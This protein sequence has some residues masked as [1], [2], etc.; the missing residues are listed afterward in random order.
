VHRI[1]GLGIPGDGSDPDPNGSGEPPTCGG[2][3]GN[4]MLNAEQRLPVDRL[5]RPLGQLSRP[6]PV[7]VPGSRNVQQVLRDLCAGVRRE[8]IMVHDQAASREAGVLLPVATWPGVEVRALNGMVLV[9]YLAPGEP[10]ERPEAGG[11]TRVNG[12]DRRRRPVPPPDHGGLRLLLVDRSAA[13]VPLQPG[14]TFAGGVLL[15]RDPAVT[16]SLHTMCATLWRHARPLPPR[17]DRPPPALQPVLDALLQ[18]LTDVAAAKRLG[19]S[20][21]T[22]SRR[23][24]DLLGVLGIA[25]RTQVGAAAL[26]KGWITNGPS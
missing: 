18:G 2:G 4:R 12:A 26:A 22:Y 14:S 19:V 8:C 24:A 25:S 13:L 17:D 21:R 7:A 16:G 6:V 11:A 15:V 9:R 10:G 1:A 23:V 20:P 3:V 5:P